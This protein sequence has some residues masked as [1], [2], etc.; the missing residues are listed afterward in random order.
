[1]T[2]AEDR[3][4]K[5]ICHNHSNFHR[6]DVLEILPYLSCLTASDQDR[7]RASYTRLGNRDTLWDL[8]NSLQRRTGWV[9]SFIAALRACELAG[10]AEEVASVYHSN[11]PR[12]PNHPPAPM[13][14][15]SVP[16][17]VPG[18]STPAVAHSIPYNGY[19][20]EDPSYPMPVQDTQPPKSLG[21]SSEQI[22][23]TPSSGAIL[24]RPAGP[25]EPSSDLAALSLLAS[26]RHQEQDTEL[27]ST[28]TA[29]VVSSLTSSCGP[30]SPTVSFQPLARSTP[31]ASRLPGPAVSAPSPGTSSSSTGLAFAGGVGDQAEAAIHS[32]EAEVP[33][34][35][36]TASTV[37][38]KLP[39]NLMPVNTVPSKVPANT[40]FASTVPSKLPT[41]PKP[42]SIVPSNVLTNPAPS[43]LPINSTRASKVPS[44]VPTSMVPTK[45]PAN[46]VPA[47]R[48]STRAEET[49]AAPAPTG[50]TGGTLPWPDSSS[51]SQQSGSELSKPGVLLS[52]LDC[53]PFS[54]CTADLAISRS[55]S[56]GAV[57]SHGVGPSHGEEPNHGPEENEY[58][59]VGTFGI[60]VAED[61]SA[62]L[63]E[64]CPRPCVTPPLKEEEVVRC[65]WDVPWAP[66]L[67]VAATGV[68]MA[69]F[70]AMLYRRRQFQ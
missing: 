5:Y 70:L 31:R 10:L 4:Y 53:Q 25:Q 50:A 28:H 24:K 68:L 66:W 59:S 56:L 23:Q 19:R 18:S 17:E 26:S 6:V 2:F 48:S 34:N 29:A 13:E 42:P 54:G 57:P 1:M 41:S 64:A 43:K 9:D 65:V 15:P 61:P 12:I 63:L 62:D 38:S 58:V 35:P 8:F 14:P 45:V 55:D 40:A 32:S 39:T 44:T 49:L 30:V 33:A 67:W 27:G 60:H 51:E 36:M 11:L 22:S 52:Q 69:T 47:S 21:E 7:L 3:T 37:P 46:T 20:E 16:A